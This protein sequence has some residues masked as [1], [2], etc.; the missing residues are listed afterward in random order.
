M[1]SED[2]PFADEE[3]PTEPGGQSIDD[4][5]SEQEIPE[6]E[7][8]NDAMTEVQ[9]DSAEQTPVGRNAY[10]QLEDIVVTYGRMISGAI[11]MFLGQPFARGHVPLPGE[12]TGIQSLALYALSGILFGAPLMYITRAVLRL[13]IWVILKAAGQT[14]RPY[15]IIRRRK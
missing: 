9:P 3:I 5:L 7:Q 4:W 1:S 13:P 15:A 2:I 11:A 14:E 10:E 6:G 8:L 12:L